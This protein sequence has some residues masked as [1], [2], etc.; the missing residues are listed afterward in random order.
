MINPK[1][2]LF[3]YGFVFGCI[4]GLK[5]KDYQYFG[6]RFNPRLAGKFRWREFPDVVTVL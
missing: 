1:L 4:S 3:I 2:Y 6:S 5:G